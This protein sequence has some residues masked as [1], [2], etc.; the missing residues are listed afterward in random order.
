MYKIRYLDESITELTP[1]VALMAEFQRQEID[2]AEI[3]KRRVQ[4]ECQK[5]N[6]NLSANLSNSHYFEHPIEQSL[7]AKK[8]TFYPYK[9]LDWQTQYDIA[10]T[11][12]K[13]GHLIVLVADKQVD[14]LSTT[15][16]LLKSEILD[17]TFI[18][19]VPLVGG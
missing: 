6:D 19:L 7:N 5:Y 10:I 18:K 11:A 13:K 17:I 14:K 12:F 1:Q 4:K 2:V 15:V 3:I 16:S 9:P 8:T